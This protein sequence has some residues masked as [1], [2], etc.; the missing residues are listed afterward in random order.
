MTDEGGHYVGR[1]FDG[2]TDDFNHFA[3]NQ[4]FNRSAYAQMENEWATHLKNGQSV[5]IEIIPS[6]T[7]D[8]LRPDALS[9]NYWVDEQTAVTRFFA[10]AAGG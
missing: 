5:R 9:V 10:N 7:G 3:Q 4:N 6:Y 1:R 2:P 8:S